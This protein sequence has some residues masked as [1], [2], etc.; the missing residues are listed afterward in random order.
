LVKELSWLLDYTQ[1]GEISRW[2]L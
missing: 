2:S 1:F